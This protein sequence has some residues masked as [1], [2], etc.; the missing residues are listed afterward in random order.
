MRTRRNGHVPSGIQQSSTNGQ[1]IRTQQNMP[2]PHAHLQSALHKACHVLGARQAARVIWM[3]CFVLPLLQC[4]ATPS[5]TATQWLSVWRRPFPSFIQLCTPSPWTMHINTNATVKKMDHCICSGWD[6]FYFTSWTYIFPCLEGYW[7]CT[8]ALAHR[9]RRILS[10]DY[11][12]CSKRRSSGNGRSDHLE[13]SP[14]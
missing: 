6:C 2:A 5:A 14:K 10:A 7:L 12:R 8:T 4:Y 1:T 13:S 3:L 11:T 9:D